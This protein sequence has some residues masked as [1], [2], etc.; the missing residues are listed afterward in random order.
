[1]QNSFVKLLRRHF[2]RSPCFACKIAFT[3]AL[4]FKCV[5][6]Y[7]LSEHVLR[8]CSVVCCI[9]LLTLICM[10]IF[11]FEKKENEKIM[12][13]SCRCRHCCCHPKTVEDRSHSLPKG[14]LY[15]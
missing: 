13:I 7:E 9:L 5:Y 10:G 3:V 1:M 8:L 4:I 14:M 2:G 6:V 12:V 11:F 15:Q